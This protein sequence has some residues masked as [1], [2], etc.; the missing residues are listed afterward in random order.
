MRDL[1]LVLVRLCIKVV[2]FTESQALIAREA[3]A[4]FGKGRHPACLNFGDCM[5][6]ALA[7]ETGEEL[8]FK[9]TDFGQTDIIPA[10]Y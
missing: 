3:F 5:S 10:P 4:K 2:P 8:L 9:G 1:D 7:K 6:Y